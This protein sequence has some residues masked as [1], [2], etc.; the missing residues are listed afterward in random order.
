MAKLP[1]VLDFGPRPDLTERRPTAVSYQT[2]TKDVTTGETVAKV[3]GVMEQI[4][5]E[6]YKQQQHLDTVRAEDA[7]TQLRL[8][9][10][11][12]T[13]GDDG[14]VQKKSGDAVNQPLATDYNSRFKAATQNIA[15][16]LGND[17]QRQLFAQ[18]AAIANVQ[19]NQDIATHLNREKEVY[20]KQVYAGGIKA[21]TQDA[22]SRRNDPNG[23]AL[24]LERINGLITQNAHA[25]GL[26][27][28]L[29]AAEKHQAI[30]NVH[31]GVVEQLIADKNRP[32]AKAYF[33]ANREAIDV[34]QQL[35]LENL[36]KTDQSEL[37]ATLADNLK[38]AQAMADRGIS[39]PPGFITNA[40]IDEAYADH[41][42]KAAQVK[43]QFALTTTYAN[44]VASL[45]SK[46]NASL[47]KFVTEGSAPTTARPD[48]FAEQAH[49]QGQLQAKAAAILEARFKTPITYAAQTGLAKVNPLNPS[50]LNAF[51]AELGNRETVAKTMREQ[52]DSPLQLM[53]KEEAGAIAQAMD[54][55]P[56]SQK[57]EYLRT[58]RSSV[59]DDASFNSVM[60]QLRPDSPVTAQAG[61]LMM[62]RNVDTL[63]PPGQRPID[64]T[65]NITVQ[66][67]WF[68]PDETMSPQDVA[69]RIIEGEAILNPTKGDKATDGKPKF[70]LPHDTELR[71]RWT[72]YVGDAYRGFEKTENES[73]QAFRA[74]YAA[75]AV[76]RGKYDGQL[77]KDIAD[78][79][80][81]AVSGGVTDVNGKNVV[82]PWGMGK[83]EFYAKAKANL[84]STINPTPAGLLEA[85]NIDLTNRPRVKNADGT[86]S[87]VRSMGVNIEGKEVLLPTV[88]DDGRIMTNDQAVEQYRK[89]GKHLGVFKDAQSSNRYAQSLHNDQADMIAGRSGPDVSK[90]IKSVTFGNLGPDPQTGE[91]MY[92]VWSGNGP[93]RGKNGEPVVLRIK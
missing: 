88:S 20:N 14:F 8:K 55:M 6:A 93:L 76:R 2:D 78:R 12:L 9:Q 68:G 13:T 65:R 85:G 17:N 22:I 60:Q 24:S 67:H 89:T 43:R 59:K 38:D 4:G 54:Q 44:S 57:L 87:T 47:I 79:A 81:I 52:F 92:S 18:R 19:F 82:L 70:A 84:E 16:T 5:E 80:A 30:S 74:F 66:G 7:F 35:H 73:Y 72:S 21:E 61:A 33:D 64:K 11:E 29:V 1:T 77:D 34:K 58:I 49:I 31:T 36:F 48:E 69:A 62:K 45:N 91:D 50:D 71:Q 28:D 25:E 56:S 37:R 53:T 90:L 83:D 10:Q 86:I 26:P 3:G 41:P 46:D 39:P 15:D 32:R 27:P 40:R 75:E 51:S 23:I 63:V 42:E